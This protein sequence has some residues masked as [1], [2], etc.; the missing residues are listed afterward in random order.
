MLTVL[1]AVSLLVETLAM[2]VQVLLEV[3]SVLPC[4]SIQHPCKSALSH[5]C[6][7]APDL[8]PGSQRCACTGDGW[9]E[10][11]GALLT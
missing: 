8:L 11:P 1:C 7:S 4:R 6:G 5:A 3:G 10:M 9:G 2:Q